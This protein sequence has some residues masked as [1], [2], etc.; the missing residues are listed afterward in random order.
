[1]FHLLKLQNK[2]QLAPK[3]L[4]IAFCELVHKTCIY[5]H[6]PKI[7]VYLF[8]KKKT[9]IYFVLSFRSGRSEREIT[10]IFKNCMW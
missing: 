4:F 10:N 2:I 6:S 8:F 7:I 1:M 9:F 5:V 3:S